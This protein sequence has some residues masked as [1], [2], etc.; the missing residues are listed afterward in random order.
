MQIKNLRIIYLLLIILV[1]FLGLLSRK[2]ETIPQY[3]GDFLYGC[4]VYFGFSVLFISYKKEWSL[5]FALVFCWFIELMQF[6]QLKWYISLQGT[7][8][9]KLILGSG[10]MVVDL[11][12][13]TFGILLVYYIDKKLN[14]AQ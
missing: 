11:I 1:V 9:G 13:Y 3:I 5:G 7:T 4:M 12:A 2:F 10:F 8:I 6:C 14:H